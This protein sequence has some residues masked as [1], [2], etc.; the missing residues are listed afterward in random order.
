MHF[1]RLQAFQIS[2]FSQFLNQN[3]SIDC[4]YIR[5]SVRLLLDLCV[6]FLDFFVP[7]V[8]PVSYLRR[9]SSPEYFG[10]QISRMHLK[11]V[12]IF[13]R[14]LT[15]KCLL[16]VSQ[17]PPLPR[18]HCRRRQTVPLPIKCLPVSSAKLYLAV[19]LI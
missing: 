17:P 2:H 8:M 11:L 4:V 5:H 6:S 15:K 13:P 1:T 19:L 7:Y 3:L 18:C 12:Y 9:H 14:N 16:T 10:S